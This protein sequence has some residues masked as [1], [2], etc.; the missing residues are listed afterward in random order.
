MD[1][2]DHRRGASAAA[3]MG[4]RV[5]ATWFLRLALILA[6]LGSVLSPVARAADCSRQWTGWQA[7]PS[8]GLFDAAPAAVL[9]NGRVSA[10]AVNA[11]RIL[12][13]SL[14]VATRTWSGW[15]ELPGNQRTDR[16]VAAVVFGT[17][18]YLFAKGVA[19]NRI[20][21]NSTRVTNSIWTG[22]RPVPGDVTTDQPVGASTARGTLFLFAKTLDGRIEINS[23]ALS[24]VWGGWT[25]V[26]G[27]WVTDAAPSSAASPDGLHVI[28]KGLNQGIHVNRMEVTTGS[29]SGWS[30][31]PGGARTDIAPSA[32]IDGDALAIV[33]HGIDDGHQYLN[34]MT[35]ADRSWQ[36]WVSV[37][38]GGTTS[39]TTAVVSASGGLLLLS[40]GSTVRGIY[41]N[42]LGADTDCD[43]VPNVSEK[44]MLS[45]F[46][47]FY[48]FS[49]DDGPDKYHPMDAL[50]FVRNSTLLDSQSQGSNVLV[51]RGTLAS[52][53][54][55]LLG[56]HTSVWGATDRRIGPDAVTP[57]QLQIALNR[58]TGEPSLAR[59]RNAAVGL[60]GHVAPLSDMTAGTI[61]GYKIEYWQFYGYNDAPVSGF[62]HEGDWE[63]IQLVVAV[64]Q[65][66]IVE[67][68]HEIHGSRAI[69][70]MRNAQRVDLGGGFIELR[71][72]NYGTLFWGPAEDQR[73]RDNVLRLFCE[74]GSCTHPVSY[75]E[76]SGHANWPTG[77]WGWV[78]A[79][80]H[81]GDA[82]AYLVATP[83][84]LGEKDAPDP[85]CRGAEI[86]MNYNGHWGAGGDSP[87]GPAMKQSWGKRP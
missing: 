63:S 17:R 15:S 78:G 33:G 65:V 19:D 38:G 66:Q 80:K 22:W 59:V 29:W 6:F 69:F 84:N 79:R 32:T 82:E 51:T 72:L 68:V 62:R 25:E 7:V 9:A 70:T 41:L 83:C 13:N 75:I 58:R 49:L 81:N 43:G 60:Y 54:L 27:Q 34:R 47:P 48:R 1:I 18:V 46:R 11:N 67:V 14:S 12:V 57:Y 3:R 31:I 28:V 5:T 86:I 4:N 40:L 77:G 74:Q 85:E 35:L 37:G 53:P 39:T 55:K 76:H 20:Y 87:E 16:A 8:G 50:S 45:R 71:G 2:V 44:Q 10:F 21:F 73:A 56:V 23:L 42:E 64:D 52:D 26:P 30:E 36:G 61:T 24:G